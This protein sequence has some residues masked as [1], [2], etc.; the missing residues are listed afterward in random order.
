MG[1]QKEVCPPYCDYQTKKLRLASVLF[2]TY[3]KHYRKNINILKGVPISKGMPF[4]LVLVFQHVLNFYLF[5]HPKSLYSIFKFL[6]WFGVASIYF[7]VL[8]YATYWFLSGFIESASNYIFSAISRVP[9]SF[10]YRSQTSLMNLSVFKN[11][12]PWI[13]IVW[14]LIK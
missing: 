14:F 10:F 1:K 7:W 4:F 11:A 5:E 12:A 6:I 9:T 8:K 2:F 13:K 3:D